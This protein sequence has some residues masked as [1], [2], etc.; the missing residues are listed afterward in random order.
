MG[1]VLLVLEGV[2]LSEDAAATVTEEG[3]FA[4]VEGHAHGFDVF[5]VRFDGVEA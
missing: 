5:D 1:E 3:D 2:G 4:E